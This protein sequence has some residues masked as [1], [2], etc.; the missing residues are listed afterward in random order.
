MCVSVCSVCVCV[1]GIKPKRTGS[2]LMAIMGESLLGGCLSQSI[3][4][5]LL[6][7]C[8]CCRVGLLLRFQ[9]RSLGLRH[10]SGQ[11]S[12][13]VQSLGPLHVRHGAERRHALV[14]RQKGAR[15]R[16]TTETGSVFG[17]SHHTAENGA[18]QPTSMQTFWAGGEALIHG[19]S[20]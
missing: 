2:Q 9:R 16:V 6:K 7:S 17:K 20:E 18:R 10:S 14:C 13:D 11:L 15:P 1:G 5:L 8:W 12:G 4:L 3:I 19:W